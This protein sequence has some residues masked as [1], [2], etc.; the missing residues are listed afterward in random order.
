MKDWLVGI[1][2]GGTKIA[3]GLVSPVGKIVAT[4]RLST[5]VQNGPEQ[6]VERTA[7]AIAH[8]SREANVTVKAAGICCPGPVD[9]VSGMI[10]DPPNLGWRNVPFRKMLSDKLG[11][12]VSLE[13]DAKAAALGEFF[14][15]AGQEHHARDLVYVIVGTGVGAAIIL[16]GQLYRGRNNA[17]GEIG[18]VTIDR[19]GEPG[20]SGV[21]G[22]V[23]SQISGPNLVKHYLRR[24]NRND[25]DLT[26]E[27]IVR[28]AREND[29]NALAVMNDAGDALGA[30]VATMASLMDVELFV[31]GG[32]VS[33]S[34]DLI[35]SPARNGLRKY[36]L[37]SIASRIKIVGTKLH[38]NAPILGCAAQAKQLLKRQKN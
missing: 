29:P 22:C 36:A 2:L 14:Y 15:G 27:D 8:L 17:S 11:L 1:D 20:S 12:P 6:A 5:E 9:H 31:I 24:V 10:I 32:S 19:N 25:A 38:E 26:G 3:L 33:R 34:G 13:H 37:E 4:L 7:E 30:A 23:E 16:D 18:H 28:F 35:L 21:L